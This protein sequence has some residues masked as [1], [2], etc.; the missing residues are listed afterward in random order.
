M[1]STEGGRLV[2]EVQS[3][4]SFSV[5]LRGSS[6]GYITDL[7]LGTFT[8]V[9][10]C[11]LLL[12][13]FVSRQVRFKFPLLLSRVLP[14]LIFLSLIPSP[15]Q[16]QRTRRRIVN[17]TSRSASSL[18]GDHLLSSEPRFVRRSWGGRGRWKRGSE[19]RVETKGE[20]HM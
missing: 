13:R 4:E 9:S 8:L 18:L 5:F 16:N 3:C 15:N 7:M 6:G 14:H 19:R 1:C 12:A 10:R 17:L 20:E 2:D 11:P